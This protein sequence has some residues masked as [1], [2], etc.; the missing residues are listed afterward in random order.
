[1]TMT[2]KQREWDNTMSY[3]QMNDYA[4]LCGTTHAHHDF[5]DDKPDKN[6]AS[7]WLEAYK[8]GTV[9][10]EYEVRNPMEVWED[11]YDPPM[12]GLADL[13]KVRAWATTYNYYYLLTTSS[14]MSNLLLM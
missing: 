3:E 7:E 4:R 14:L 12:F 1:M 11:I 6:M 2:T 13:R 10:W 5:H 8:A 9:A